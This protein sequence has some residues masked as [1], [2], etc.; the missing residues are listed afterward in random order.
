MN[1]MRW[2][3]CIVCVAGCSSGAD[4]GTSQADCD[5]IAQE[6]HDHGGMQGVC[7]LPMMPENV[8]RFGKACA[9][10]KDCQ[11]HVTRP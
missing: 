11:D 1:V 2:I 6:I 3:L 5:K 10:L 7:H 9:A 4:G 8:E